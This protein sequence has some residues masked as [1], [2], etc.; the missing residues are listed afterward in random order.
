MPEYLAPGVY[1]EETSFR[2]KSIE[3]VGTSTTA[4]VGPTRRGPVGGVPEL[5]TSL[6]DFERIYGSLENL[7]L[8][9][10]TD[11]ARR[12]NFVGHAARAYFDNGGSR[13]YVV[14]ALNA[15]DTA[16]GVLLNGGADAENATIRARFAGAAYNGRVLFREAARPATVRTLGTAPAGS[17][18]SIRV[19]D[20]E[21][22]YVGSGTAWLTSGNTALALDGLAPEATPGPADA[23]ANIVTLAVDVVDADG[24]AQSWDDLGFAPGH[25]RFIGT[26]LAQEPANRADALSNLVA[27]QIGTGVSGFELAAA[28]RALPAVVGD[29]DGRRLLTLAGGSDGSAPITGAEGTAGSYADALATLSGLED[30]SIVAAPGSS[31]YADGPAV[32]GALIVHA[33]RR[34]AYRIAVLDCAPNQTPG[35]MRIA[36]GRI[37]SKYAA[38]YYPWVIVSNPLARPGREDIPREISLPPSGFVAGIYAR[39]DT[40]RGVYK[41][42]ANEVVAGALRFETD[43]NFAQQEVLNPIG[44]NCLRYLSGRGYR[45][46][47]ARLASSDPEWKYVSDRRYFNYLE[48]SIDR[49]TQW[50]VFEPNGERLWANVRQTISDY[51]YNEWRGGALLGSTTEEAFFVRCDRTTMT[52][53]DLDNGRLICLIGVAIIKPA[54]FVIFRIGQKTA[55]ARA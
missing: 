34:R 10:V 11:A 8:D 17:L 38:L 5:V 7:D 25:P 44:V 18:L 51:L 40:Q 55:D 3:G 49:G 13:L 22:L 31:A 32:Q 54:E 36:R 50:A 4:F 19:D 52:Q 29:T 37:D 14:R 28:V 41:A 42:P 24:Y 47:G 1:V 16:S 23:V 20:A 21:T 45:V 12:L 26:V 33:E 53:N 46:W 48:S 27:A 2:A 9:D 15:A 35:D 6:P 39:N 43:I 30:I